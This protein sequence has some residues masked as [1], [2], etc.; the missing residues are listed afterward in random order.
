[1]P[2]LQTENQTGPYRD[3]L[4][5]V[6]ALVKIMVIL[7]ALLMAWVIVVRIAY[8]SIQRAEQLLP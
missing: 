8:V 2:T 1:M 4:D 3:L 6:S 7:V 5:G